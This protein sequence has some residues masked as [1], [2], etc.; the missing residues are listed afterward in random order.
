MFK[1][2]LFSFVL[3][4][5]RPRGTFPLF[6]LPRAKIWKLWQIIQRTK[7]KWKWENKRKLYLNLDTSNWMTRDMS[8]KVYYTKK[9][10]NFCS[11]EKMV[12]S[13][14]KLIIIINKLFHKFNN[15]CKVSINNASIHKKDMSGIFKFKCPV[16]FSKE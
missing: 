7:Q 11:K 5:P 4:P 9:L 14:K 8:N 1:L 2:I 12:S 16:L 6:H 13:T 15:I 10:N 3:L